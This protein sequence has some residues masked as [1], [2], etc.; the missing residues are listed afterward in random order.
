MTDI[1]RLRPMN[2][3]GLALYIDTNVLDASDAVSVFL[4]RLG[5]MGW[6]YLQ[7]TDTM[8]H[9]LAAAPSDKAATLLG[10]SAQ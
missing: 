9:E 4:R 6:I 2:L 1:S 5:E 3:A 7:R 10:A 8:D